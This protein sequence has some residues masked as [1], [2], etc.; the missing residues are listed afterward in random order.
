M[1]TFPATERDT[2]EAAI[3]MTP[4]RLEQGS[5]WS[6]LQ[7]ELNREAVHTY[8]CYCVYVWLGDVTATPLL[9]RFLTP[10]SGPG[11]PKRRGLSVRSRRKDGREDD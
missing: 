4:P 5:H 9:D 8:S 1:E 11:F 6:N 3:R 7:Y 2:P 10:P